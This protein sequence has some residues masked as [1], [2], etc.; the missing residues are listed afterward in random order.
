ML[1]GKDAHHYCEE[2]AAV[3][4]IEANFIRLIDG[5]NMEMLGAIARKLQQ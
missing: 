1:I 2:M 3:V 5:E 4:L